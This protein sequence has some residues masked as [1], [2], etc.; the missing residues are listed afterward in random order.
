MT[1]KRKFKSPAFEAIPLETM[2]DF[3]KECI[4]S[5]DKLQP[6]E[7]TAYSRRPLSK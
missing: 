4:A 3:D 5:V 7:I 1:A 6:A 2:R